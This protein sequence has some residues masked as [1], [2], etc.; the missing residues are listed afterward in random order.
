MVR[1][2]L[3]KFVDNITV[4]YGVSYIIL[5]TMVVLLVFYVVRTYGWP[6]EISRFVAMI[7]LIGCL[8][9]FVLIWICE[10]ADPTDRRL[11]LREA[12]WLVGPPFIVG[13]K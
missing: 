13:I 8:Y 7:A 1:N 12:N 9:V 6:D 2:L 11:V 5:A 4:K 3:S 10:P